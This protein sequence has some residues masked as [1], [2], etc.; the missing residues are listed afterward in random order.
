MLKGRGASLPFKKHLVLPE[1]PQ[2]KQLVFG[3]AL[4]THP[5][6]LAMGSSEHRHNY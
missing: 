1:K 4:P 6:P 2:S 3:S 5:F